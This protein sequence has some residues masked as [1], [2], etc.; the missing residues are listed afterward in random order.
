[1]DPH[2]HP[3]LKRT[4]LTIVTPGEQYHRPAGVTTSTSVRILSPAGHGTFSIQNTLYLN[5]H[6]LSMRKM[7]SMKGALGPADFKERENTV[8]R[9]MLKQSQRS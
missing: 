4:T 7:V 1:M 2:F 9:Y 3:A 6:V 5:K 8:T